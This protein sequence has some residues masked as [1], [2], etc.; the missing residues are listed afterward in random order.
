MAFPVILWPNAL[1]SASSVI[2]SYTEPGFS[3]DDAYDYLPWRVWKSGTLISS[4]TIDI[5]MGSSADHAHTLGFVNHNI[6]S[7]ECSPPLVPLRS[8]TS[9]RRLLSHLTLVW[10]GWEALAG[11]LAGCV[12]MLRRA[13]VRVWQE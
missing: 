1:P 3:V 13:V 2:A 12:G 5:D 4:I 6:A 10:V 11:R 7:Q 9:R 8:A